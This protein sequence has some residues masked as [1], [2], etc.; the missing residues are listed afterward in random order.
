MP[1]LRKSKV[2]KVKLQSKARIR[3]RL[4]KWWSEGVRER[5]NHKC[6]M[7]GATVAAGTC[8]KVDAHHYLQRNIKDCPLKFDL[9]DGGT[10][11]PSCHKFNGEK[12]AHKSPIVFYDW[13]HVNRP[14]HYEFV[15]KNAAV[16]VD[17]NN[18]DILAEIEARLMRSEILDLEKLVAIDKAAKGITNED[19]NT[20]QP[21]PHV[22]SEQGSNAAVSLPAPD[23]SSGQ[24]DLFDVERT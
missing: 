11:C 19:N 10:L 13:L 20:G 24:T 7:C 8:T 2:K 6:I 3:R 5:D 23:T 21:V 14:N 4:F 12:S 17:L 9:R 1:R 22:P 16:R 18:R 15:L